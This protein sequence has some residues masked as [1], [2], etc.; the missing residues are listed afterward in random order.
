MV[1]SDETCKSETLPEGVPDS[2]RTNVVRVF[3]FN[4]AR[5]VLS[6]SGRCAS[7]RETPRHGFAARMKRSCAIFCFLG[8]KSYVVVPHVSLISNTILLQVGV[9]YA[10]RLARH[11]VNFLKFIYRCCFLF[12]FAKERRLC[13]ESRSFSQVLWMFVV[14]FGIFV[15]V[16]TTGAT[17]PRIPKREHFH[18]S[19]YCHRKSVVLFSRTLHARSWSP[20]R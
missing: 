12:F 10:I 2:C 5:C 9:Q 4:N 20:V 18:L 1:I 16:L 3:P 17:W 19:L 8:R 6:G 7:R 15:H 14:I 11:L 13:V